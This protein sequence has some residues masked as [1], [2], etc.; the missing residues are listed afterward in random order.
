MDDARRVHGGYPT[1][2]LMEE[3]E[4]FVARKYQTFSQ[5]RLEGLTMEQLHGQEQ[6]CRWRLFATKD[7]V[8]GTEIGV[9]DR[10]GEEYLLLKAMA[11]I[12]VSSD[13]RKN[14]LQR[15][16]VAVKQRIFYLIHLAHAA[17]RNESDHQ[18]AS[19]YRLSGREARAFWRLCCESAL[20]VEG[21]EGC[22]R[23]AP[24]PGCERLFREAASTLVFAQQFF[25]K[26]PQRWCIA[27]R[28][29]QESLS[30]ARLLLDG[31]SEKLLYGLSLLP[32]ELD[33]VD[34]GRTASLKENSDQG[35]SRDGMKSPEQAAD[36]RLTS[37]RARKGGA[38]ALLW[39]EPS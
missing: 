20:R 15:H 13:L 4:R 27:A 24:N 25:N 36:V 3:L 39:R 35:E 18:E 14:C 26:A 11:G 21:R 1:D 34:W 29:I 37:Q 6:K 38:N 30:G 16:A 31:N 19:G 32:H 17:A 5:S 12:G 8:D 28:P 7:L 22:A 10:P 9:M 23:G 2:H 33:P